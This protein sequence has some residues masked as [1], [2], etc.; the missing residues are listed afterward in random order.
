MNLK[1]SNA[2]M[3]G[4]FLLLAHITLY[5]FKCWPETGNVDVVSFHALISPEKSSIVILAGIVPSS[6]AA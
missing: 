2:C 1:C 3:T 4:Q 6:A 5:C